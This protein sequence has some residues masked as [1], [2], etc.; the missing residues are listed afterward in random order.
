M[1]QCRQP[2]NDDERKKRGDEDL[3][4][5]KAR[6]PVNLNSDVRHVIS[7]RG[8]DGRQQRLGLGTP[9]RDGKRSSSRRAPNGVTNTRRTCA[10]VGSDGSD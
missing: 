4:K 8:F 9:E 10:R 2:A 1:R 6:I 7:P 3:E 5:R